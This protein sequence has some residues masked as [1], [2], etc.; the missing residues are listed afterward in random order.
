MIM[1][2]NI[3]KLALIAHV[4]SSVGWF[5]A[6]GVFLALAVI[7]LTSQEPERV[8]AVYIAMDL[9]GWYVIVP[10]CFVSLATGFIQA[11]GTTWGL[12]R[13]YW[14]VSK[15]LI[16]VLATALLVMHM[17]PTDRVAGAAVARILSGADLHGL[18]VQLAVDAG[19]ALLALLTATT[20]SVYKPR[21]LTQYGLC[22]QEEQ[23]VASYRGSITNAWRWAYFFGI[24]AIVLMVVRHLT[25]GGHHGGYRVP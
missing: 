18:R 23:G 24:I 8:R 5:G 11:L 20:L 22:K 6:V 13:H 15:L 4:T 7:G 10:L 3:R 14:V 2:P 25:V 9:S 17:G 12:F 1:P 19:A 21:G 16:T